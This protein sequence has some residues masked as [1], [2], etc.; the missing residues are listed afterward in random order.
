MKKLYFLLIL[1][2]VINNLYIY[3]QMPPHPLLLDKINKGEIIK[4]Y[5]LS[6]LDMIRSKGV[7]KPWSAP[8]Q[9]LLNKQNGLSRMFGPQT[10]PSGSWKALAVLVQFTDKPSQVNA[11]YFD[12]L[13]FG[14]STG[15]L[16]NYYNKVSYGNLDIITVT[17]PSTLGWITAPQPYSY[18]VN[19]NNGM[20]S[21]PQNS[22]KLVEDIVNLI[23]P[24]IDFSQYDNDGDGYVDALFIVHSGS[25][26]EHNGNNNDM[27]SHSW[28]T[29]T[30]PILDEVQ[31]YHY[32]IVPEYWE[33][34]GDM[35]CGVFAHEMGHSVFGLP[36]LYDTDYSSMGL[37]KWSLTAGGSWNGTLG[38]SPAFPDAWSHIQMGYLNPTV[39]SD[40]ISDQ[41]I[42]N[43]ENNAEAYL[44]KNSLCGTEYFLVENRQKIGYDA[45][46]PGSGLCIYH[47][48]NSAANNNNEWY[49]GHTSSGHYKVALMQA[50]GLWSLEHSSSGNSGDPYPGSSNNRNFGSISIPD[51]WNYNLSETGIG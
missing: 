36:D 24:V 33:T 44:L 3:A 34:A 1:L 43:V 15:T 12:N 22:Q 35:T 10:V 38:N 39:V 17:L 48:D 47:V 16:S 50:D 25:G 41:S 5:A 49:P 32:S 51:S 28:T 31:I 8:K 26:A 42:N 23:D 27:W 45:Y 37:G 14:Q 19:G 40:N 20:G 30:K 9:Q 7:D 21:Y 2:L 46:L 6:N 4:P 29:H 18:Y 11:T 13:L